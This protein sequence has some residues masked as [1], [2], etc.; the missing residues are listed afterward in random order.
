MAAL[1]SAAQ[2]VAGQSVTLTPPYGVPVGNKGEVVVYNPTPFDLQVSIGG[3]QYILQSLTADRYDLVSAVEAVVTPLSGSVAAGTLLGL[4]SSAWATL[5]DRI[6]GVYPLPL[7]PFPGGEAQL[8]LAQG[9]SSYSVALPPGTGSITVTGP[10]TGYVTVTGV[11]TGIEYGV[12]DFSSGSATVYLPELMDPAVLI[13]V[14]VVAGTTVFAGPPLGPPSSPVWIGKLS[15]TSAS[16][17]NINVPNVPAKSLVFRAGSSAAIVSIAITG[18]DQILTI[19]LDGTDYVS[20]AVPWFPSTG[21]YGAVGTTRTITATLTVLSGTMSSAALD[22]FISGDAAEPP[23]PYVYGANFAAT[24]QLDGNGVPA[25]PNLA[26]GAFA[27]TANP[28]EVLGAPS[29]GAW[30]LYSVTFQPG[31]GSAVGALGLS[32]GSVQV[33]GATGGTVAADPVWTTVPLEGLRTG[34][35]VNGTYAANTGYIDLSY[36]QGL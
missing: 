15:W 28:T 12:A 33:C 20:V 18:T 10:S 29:W 26:I 1:G 11:A 36:A 7:P 34:S 35:Q 25:G 2:L 21:A 5:P 4:V 32:V 8:T 19:V 30:Y 6:G 14:S 27:I 3:S 24:Y 23:P 31:S 17:Q 16:S 13:Q 22:V 9:S